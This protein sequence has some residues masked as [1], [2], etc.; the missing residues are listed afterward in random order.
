L[1]VYRLEGRKYQQ[2]LGEPVWMPEIGLGIGREFGT[3]QGW[4]REWLYWYDHQG[5][6]LPTTEEFAELVEQTERALQ[7]LW[8]VSQQVEQ[9]RQRAEQAERRAEQLAKLLRDQGID[10]D[11]LK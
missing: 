11:T 6:R 7:R 3:Y 10:P 5:T 2:R 4:Q 1:E 8:Q 9:E